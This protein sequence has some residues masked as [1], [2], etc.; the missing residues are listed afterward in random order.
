MIFPLLLFLIFSSFTIFFYEICLHSRGT[1]LFVCWTL[2]CV[3]ARVSHTNKQTLTHF[4]YD[5]Y[6]MIIAFY[7]NIFFSLLRISLLQS[8]NKID[9]FFAYNL[10]NETHQTKSTNRSTTHFGFFFFFFRLI[11]FYKFTLLNSGCFHLNKYYNKHFLSMRVVKW[12]AMRQKKKIQWK[13]NEKKKN[14]NW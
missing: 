3:C 12:R 5:N 9:A 10:M 7:I 13:Q 1:M 4:Q 6:M 8:Q 14:V 2:G 11:L